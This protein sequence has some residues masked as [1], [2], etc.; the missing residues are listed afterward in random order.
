MLN[1]NL[2]HPLH[3]GSA[4]GAFL[5]HLGTVLTGAHVA[6][7][8]HGHALFHFQADHTQAGLFD[9]FFLVL[10]LLHLLPQF[11]FQLLFH[12]SLHPLFNLR[13]LRRC[14]VPGLQ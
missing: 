10:H 11:L 14:V 6:A 2:V 9:A 5:D 4:D 12:L 8:H 3:F 1:E 13:L 7:R